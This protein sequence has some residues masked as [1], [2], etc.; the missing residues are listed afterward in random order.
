SG[1]ASSYVT[2][3]FA[4]KG[5]KPSIRVHWMDGGIQPERPEELAANEQMG[6]GGNGVIFVGTKGKMMCS[7]YGEDPKLIPLSRNGEVNVPETIAR[8]PNGAGGHYAQWVEACIAGYDS[9][10]A[11]ALSSPFEIAGPLTETVLMGNLA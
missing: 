7:T 2:L 3:K 5:S 9:D 10:K 1:P 6:D 4:G 8:V 11:K